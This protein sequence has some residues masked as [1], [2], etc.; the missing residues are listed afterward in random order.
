MTTKIIDR[1]TVLTAV[2]KVGVGNIGAANGVTIGLR[3]GSLVMRVL[4]LTTTAFNA[5]STG[6]NTLTV[7]DGTTTFANAVDVKTTGS[8]TV[9]NAPK[10]YPTGGTLAVTLAETVVTTAADAGQA[11]VVVEYVIDNRGTE[12]QE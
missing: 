6:T 7:G 11:F 9:A 12:I 10:Y 5:G 4:V 1:Q 3:P 2:A 8:E